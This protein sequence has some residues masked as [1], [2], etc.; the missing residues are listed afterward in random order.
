MYDVVVSLLISRLLV[1]EFLFLYLTP[2]VGCG[3][4][5]KLLV[6]HYEPFSVFIY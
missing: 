6:A 3:R 5:M 1:C 2:G 4:A